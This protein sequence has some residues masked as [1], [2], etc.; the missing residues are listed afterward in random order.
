MIQI[1]LMALADIGNPELIAKEIIKENK[2][3]SLPIPI[4]I[5]RA[6]V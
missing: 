4:E 5:G 3:T 6:H 2:D 1:D